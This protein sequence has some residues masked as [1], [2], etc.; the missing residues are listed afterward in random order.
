[1]TKKETGQGSASYG[2]YECV[3]RREEYMRKTG[4]EDRMGAVEGIM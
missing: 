4:A 2:V 3:G 1:M